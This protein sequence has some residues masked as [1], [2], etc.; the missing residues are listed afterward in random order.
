MKSTWVR[1]KVAKRYIRRFKERLNSDRKKAWHPYSDHDL[2]V[3]QMTVGY[4]QTPRKVKIIP[5]NAG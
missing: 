4:E 3:M 2:G 5:K 1:Y